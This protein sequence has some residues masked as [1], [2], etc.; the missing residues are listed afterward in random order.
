MQLRVA[1]N[2]AQHKI[3]YSIKTFVRFLFKVS[4]GLDMWELDGVCSEQ[5][6][7]SHSD[8]IVT[9]GWRYSSGLAC[10]MHRA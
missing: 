8:S 9:G 4:G 2:V 1:M 3:I 10:G 5:H 7:A 6:W